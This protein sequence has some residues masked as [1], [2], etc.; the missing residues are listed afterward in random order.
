[1]TKVFTALNKSW[2]PEC[3]K[4]EECDTP[5]ESQYKMKGNNAYHMNCAVESC[6]VC[7]KSLSGEYY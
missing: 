3:F 4:C 6:Y 5:I 2:H 1:M 7:K